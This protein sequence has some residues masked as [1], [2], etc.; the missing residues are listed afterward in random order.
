MPEKTC[1]RLLHIDGPL[2][3]LRIVEKYCQAKG[4]VVDST[5]S[6]AVGFHHALVKR[7]KLILIGAHV[8]RID[9]FRILKGLARAKVGS[10]VFFT[11]ESPNK[12][13]KWVGYYP[14]LMGIIAKPLDLKD[15][16]RYLEY[17]EAPPKLET[18]ERE[19]IL[20]VLGK[21]EKCL[22]VGG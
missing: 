15:F 20:A 12:D 8:P 22:K 7:Y 16:S 4:M 19:K 10:P 17:A 11:S 3:F 21:W 5:D 13:A 9:A 14:N 6:E 2:P 18:G 1:S